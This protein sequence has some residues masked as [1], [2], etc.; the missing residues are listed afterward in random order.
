ME[1]NIN[2]LEKELLRPELVEI[3]TDSG[4]SIKDLVKHGKE[5][6][7]AVKVRYDKYGDEIDTIP[8]WTVRNKYWAGFMEMYKLLSGGGTVVNNNV[9]NESK[10]I[11][12]EAI[13]RWKDNLSTNGG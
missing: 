8:D 2:S 3:M 9:I 4:L 12:D 5:G 13:K 7:S 10:K 1:K 6:M 11:K